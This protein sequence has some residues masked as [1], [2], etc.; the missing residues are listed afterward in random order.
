M[1]VELRGLRPTDRPLLEAALRSDDTFTAEEIAVALELIDDALARA[2]SDYWF[3]VA[4]AP[5]AP[6]RIAGYI[7]YGPTPMTRSSF[8]LYWL[9]VHRDA[10]GRGVAR[11]LIDEMERDLRARGATGVRIETSQLESYGAARRVYERH[12]YRE[13]AR[14]PD[15]YKPG[16]A[17]VT[18]YKRL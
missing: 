7:C 11:A 16:D 6:G 2:D 9:V 3:R 12:G 18:F 5:D 8:D 15:F 13:V 10:R 1:T 17:L 14:I 4:V